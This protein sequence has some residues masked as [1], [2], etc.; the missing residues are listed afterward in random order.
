MTA[1]SQITRKI[2]TS[3]RDAI[4]DIFTM[5][6]EQEAKTVLFNLYYTSKDKILTDK[7]IDNLNE[8]FL[9]QCEDLNFHF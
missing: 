3:K 2:Y 9:K 4:L 8:A 6:S 7:V 1:T 5:E